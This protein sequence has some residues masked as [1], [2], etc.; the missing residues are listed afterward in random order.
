MRP[1]DEMAM[2]EFCQALDRLEVEGRFED[3]ERMGAP[4]ELVEAITGWLED[5][6]GDSRGVGGLALYRRMNGYWHDDLDWYTY[7]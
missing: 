6:D 1:N 2:V 7:A 5:G 4:D 3:M